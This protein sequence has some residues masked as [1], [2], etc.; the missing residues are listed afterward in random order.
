M[1]DS[2]GRRNA[3]RLKLNAEARL[4][5]R[6]GTIRVEVTDISATGAHLRYHGDEPFTW[7]ILRWL[8][9]EI[10]GEMVWLDAREAGIRF[11]RRL[12]D[13]ALLHYKREFPNIDESRR[14][15][16]PGRRRRI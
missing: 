5:T 2:I 15:P 16:T 6:L 1:P 13:E 9:H 11:I 3:Q 10:D 7:C 14:L 12:P 8:G 4:V